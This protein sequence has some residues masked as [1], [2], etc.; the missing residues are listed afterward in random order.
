MQSELLALPKQVVLVF[1]EAYFDNQSGRLCLPKQLVLVS[2]VAFYADQG[3]KEASCKCLSETFERLQDTATGFYYQ[4]AGYVYSFLLNE[5][6][7][8]RVA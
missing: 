6:K 7:K 5:L 3:L 2:R 4:S 8:G 1:K